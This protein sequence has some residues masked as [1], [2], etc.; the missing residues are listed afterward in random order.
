M[1]TAEFAWIALALGAGLAWFG[2]PSAPATYTGVSGYLAG[3][4]PAGRHLA[5]NA[6]MSTAGSVFGALMLTACAAAGVSLVRLATGSRSAGPTGLA[7][8]FV[9]YAALSLGLLGLAASGLWYPAVLTVFLGVF[10]VLGLPEYPALARKTTRGVAAAWRDL[11]APARAGAA[12]VAA[13]VLPLLLAPETNVDCYQYH[14]AFPQQLL[15]AH[16]L[17]G[18]G[19][20]LAWAYPLAADLPNVYP[21]MLRLDAATRIMRP[22]LAI[23]GVL[24]FVRSLGLRLAP[25][26]EAGTVLLALAVPVPAF[27][28]LSAKN[29]AV[30]AGY[31]LACAGLLLSSGLFGRGAI[32]PALVFLSGVFC[33][34]LIAS[35]YVMLPFVAALAVVGLFRV[36]HGLRARTAFLLAAGAIVPLLPWM[37]RSEIY[38]NDPLYPAGTLA[39]P[40]VFGDP[41]TNS[42]AAA[43]YR[44]FLQETRPKTWFPYETVVLLLRNSFPL[45]AAIPFLWSARLPNVDYLLA[46]VALG[47]AGTVFGIRGGLDFV[48]RFAYPAF[49]VFNAAAGAF[50]FRERGIG[51]R[52]WQVLAVG[53]LAFGLV[54]GAGV[55][56]LSGMAL[57]YIPGTSP[58]DYVSGRK[59]AEEYRLA[60]LNAY[61]AVLPA[62]RAAVAGSRGGCVLHVGETISWDIPVRVIQTFLDPPFMWKAVGESDVEER[63]EIRFRQAGV[64]WILYNAPVAGFSRYNYS[65]YEWTPRMLGLYSGYARRHF[66]LLASSGRTDPNYGCDWLYAVAGRPFRPADRILFLPGIERT[67]SYAALAEL[68]RAYDDAII[69]FSEIRKKLPAVVWPD[70]LLGHSLTLAGRWREAYPLVRGSV[71]EGLLD[72]WNLLD[73]AVAA[74]KLG[75]R[76]EATEALRRAT[77]A[78]PLW[79]ERVTEARKATGVS[80][81][82][83]SP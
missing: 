20:Y 56:R 60:G 79:P 40:H 64:R 38:L 59:D 57:N 21:V 36:K 61:G 72:E 5:V 51:G 46:S 41:G 52:S 49:V 33:G 53:W 31:A 34:V 7:G 55:T 82:M 2:V 4:L 39:L 43:L 69:R 30:V 78:Y 23:L 54:A 18:R 9:G 29:D 8:V 42:G 35:K 45:V 75:K 77:A 76:D 14:L 62:V 50:I 47:L 67:F 32:R 63:L 58:A 65:P 70:A 19:V 44:I 10:L 15:V 6:G 28:L 48:E 37:V 25:A 83:V 27:C 13:L 81:K 71:R 17:F 80:D 12:L 73:W 11:S 1:R 74:A 3:I 24:L 26:R 22:V 66:R 68:N 16:R